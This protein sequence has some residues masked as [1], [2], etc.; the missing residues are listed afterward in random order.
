MS[1]DPIATFTGPTTALAYRVADSDDNVASST[2]V[3]TVAPV[4]PVAVDDSASTPFA[5]PVDL[6]VLGN[7]LAGDDSAPLDH[8]S[9]QL[10]DSDGT[11]KSSVTIDGQGTFAVLSDGSVRFTPAAGFS[12]PVDVVTYRVADDNGT[13]ASATIT[14]TVGAAPVAGDDEGST[15]QDV[16]VTVDVLDNDLAGTG[17]TLVPGM[18]QLQDPADSSWKTTVTVAGRGHLDGRRLDRRGHLRPRGHLHRHRHDHLPGDRLGRQH[19]PGR[20]RHRGR[21]GDPGRQGRLRQHA[22]RPPGRRAG[23]RQRRRG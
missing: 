21:P 19:G 11:W 2:V 9:V 4:T 16:D 7:D 8:G 20:G 6:T 15:K 1:F 14:V 22:V 10:K 12:G 13:H 17:A 18:V 23:A 3:V 5:H